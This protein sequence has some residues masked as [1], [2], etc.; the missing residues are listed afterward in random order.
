MMTPAEI[1]DAVWSANL[2]VE[3]RVFMLGDAVTLAVCKALLEQ[4]EVLR[5]MTENPFAEPEEKAAR[6]RE[7]GLPPVKWRSYAEPGTM[8]TPEGEVHARA[9]ADARLTYPT[10]MLVQKPLEPGG[11]VIY[12]PAGPFPSSPLQAICTCGASPNRL[13]HQRD[14]NRQ[15]FTDGIRVTP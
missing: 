7:L 10:G 8:G 15:L 5:S 14:E 9:R 4:T 13:P 6:Y 12:L 1:K 2:L 11:E 3:G